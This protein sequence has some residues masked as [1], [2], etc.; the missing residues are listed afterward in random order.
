MMMR[1]SCIY[2]HISFIY[3]G[4]RLNKFK[5]LKAAIENEDWDKASNEIIDSK[6]YV[7]V[8]NASMEELSGMHNLDIENRTGESEKFYD[9]VEGQIFDYFFEMVKTHYEKTLEKGC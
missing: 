6:Y 5:N 8:K 3:G 1:N 4:T 2:M 9:R 7:D